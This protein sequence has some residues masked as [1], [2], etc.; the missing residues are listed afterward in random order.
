MNEITDQ[1][2]DTAQRRWRL[3]HQLLV[4]VLVGVVPLLSV[5]AYLLYRGAADALN[6]ARDTL[7]IRAERGATVM[8]DFLNV[9]QDFLKRIAERPLVRAV[10]PA[11]CDPILADFSSVHPRYANIV[12]VDRAG[13]VICSAKPQPGGGFQ[14][15]YYHQLQRTPKILQVLNNFDCSSSWSP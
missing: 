11:R 9:T 6:N 14:F 4:L 3:R 15:F 12:V 13:R 10:D 5:Q 2:H 1:A 8:Q 7:A